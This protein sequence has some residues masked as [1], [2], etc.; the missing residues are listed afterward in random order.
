MPPMSMGTANLRIWRSGGPLVMSL[1]KRHN[2]SRQESAAR[3][4]VLLVKS[5]FESGKSKHRP[6]RGLHFQ[7]MRRIPDVILATISAAISAK[8]PLVLLNMAM[9][10][11]FMR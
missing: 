11:S 8:T 5:I 6:T 7:I 1:S 4:V 9:T 10:S 2:P 3:L